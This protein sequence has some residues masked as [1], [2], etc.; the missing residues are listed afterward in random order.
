MNIYHEALLCWNFHTGA[1]RSK[2][3]F[4]NAVDELWLNKVPS[5]KAKKG[6]VNASYRQP[7]DGFWLFQITYFGGVVGK[8]TF[9]DF[10]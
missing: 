5:V 8:A 10:G 6:C 3:E 9:R 7:Q 2:I 1:D 4:G